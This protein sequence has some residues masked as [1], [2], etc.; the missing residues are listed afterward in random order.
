MSEYIQNTQAWLDLRKSKIGSSDA[1][2]IMGVSPFTTPYQLWEEKIGLKP[3][4]EV[5]EAMERGKR[6]EPE[7]RRKFEQQ[8]GMDFF[9]EVR[10]HPQYDWMLASLDG[11]NLEGNR[12]V[13]IKCP[14]TQD[15]QIALDGKVPEKYIPQL[16]HQMEVCDLD[17]IFYFSFNGSS[18]IILEIERDEKFIQDMLKKEQEF[19]R[20]MK[21]FDPPHLSD[22]DFIQRD[23]EE[24]KKSAIKWVTVQV[25][26]KSL[27]T[28]EEYLRKELIA[29]AGSHNTMGSGVRLSKVIRKGNVDYKSI[30]E[31]Q[32]MDLEKYRKPPIETWRLSCN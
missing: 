1:P 13:E 16:Q 17:F 25:Q 2:I 15:H 7:A 11:I 20:C 18:G 14:G 12:A 21:E 4:K 22:K 32:V 23:D 6:L 3:F 28:E 24:W 5:T 19:F 26:I 9:P 30:P 31:I 10:Q 8:I 27:Q 29:M